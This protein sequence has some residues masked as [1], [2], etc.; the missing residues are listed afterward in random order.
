MNSPSQEMHRV[1]TMLIL[2]HGR[3]QHD[4]GQWEEAQNRSRVIMVIGLHKGELGLP[5]HTPKKY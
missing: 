1:R 2:Y 4:T 3:K 5:S